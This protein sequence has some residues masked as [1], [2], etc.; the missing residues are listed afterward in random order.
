M[1]SSEQQPLLRTA[2]EPA[3]RPRQST[4]RRF[5]NIAIS[6]SFLGFLLL[7]LIPQALFDEHRH[8]HWP[9][10]YHQPGHRRNDTARS[11]ITYAELQE[12]LL[13]SPDPD[14][15]SNSSYYYTHGSHLA[16]Q[17]YSQALWTKEKWEDYGLKSDIVTYETLINYPLDH[18]LA[19]YQK[20][21]GADN[22]SLSNT[23][24]WVLK[25]EASLEEDVLEEVPTT[26][27]PDRVPTFHGYSATGNVTGSFVYVNYGSYWDFEDLLKANVSLKGRIA[28]AR[29]GGIF[30]GLKV[31][32]AQELGM[33][34][35]VLFSEPGDDRREDP[36]EL[37]YPDGPARNPSSVQR[38]SVQFLSIAPGDP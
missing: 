7:V 35:V 23:N 34:G 37:T 13:T 6:S 29:Y 18:R 2:H 8:N 14:R 21:S 28:I 38:G 3:R 36:G 12:I 17:N 10:H 4:S 19:L 33:I 30:R 22:I 1:S 25:F 20:P 15:I 26:G 16:G 11:K 32:R 27:S 24:T 31:K 5:C 9:P